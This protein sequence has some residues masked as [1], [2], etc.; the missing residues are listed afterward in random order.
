MNKIKMSIKELKDLVSFC[1]GNP[2]K[3]E[4]WNANIENNTPKT[5][6]ELKRYPLK[7]DFSYL[8]SEK[9]APNFKRVFID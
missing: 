3:V 5:I 6:Q 2:N 8:L 7:K 4:E 1:G 9:E